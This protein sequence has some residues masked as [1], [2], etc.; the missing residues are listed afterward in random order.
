[1]TQPSQEKAAVFLRFRCRC[2]FCGMFALRVASLTRIS[3]GSACV[4]GDQRPSETS[5]AGSRRARGS[6][7]KCR[8]PVRRERGIEHFVATTETTVTSAIDPRR[9]PDAVSGRVR[10]G[11]H[12]A[13][14]S[15]SADAR[16][17]T[18]DVPVPTGRGT[19]VGRR[20]ESSAHFRRF[21]VPTEGDEFV[22]DDI[23]PARSDRAPDVGELSA[24]GRAGRE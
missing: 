17:R 20:P 18:S 14:S 2:S 11:G 12:G 3:E 13:P 1:M 5:V 24:M 6:R 9:L 8:D 19:T 21:S 4:P 16:H 7:R 10:R 22:M 23:E 15:P